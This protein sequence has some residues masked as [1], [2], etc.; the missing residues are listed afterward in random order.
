MLTQ[1]ADK[2]K[3]CPNAHATINGYTDS[4]G[5]EGIDIPL[6]AQRTRT[7][8]DL[9]IAHGVARDHLVVK[10]LGS[11]DPIASNDTPDG[12]AKNRCVEIAVN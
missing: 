12:R 9:L 3:A 6:S 10:G 8:A 5:T 2:L 1:V 7:V 11:F 4:A